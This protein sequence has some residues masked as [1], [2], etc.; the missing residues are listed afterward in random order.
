[1]NDINVT[2]NNNKIEKTAEK[3]ILK[4]MCRFHLENRLMQDIGTF[5]QN[6]KKEVSDTSKCV[7]IDL[8]K[9]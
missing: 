1:M 4:C 2:K 7:S 3:T 8:R 5:Y 9:H 6:Q